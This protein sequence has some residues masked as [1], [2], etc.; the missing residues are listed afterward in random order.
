VSCVFE[1]LA[2]V[3]GGG[4]KSVLE[5]FYTYMRGGL[6]FFFCLKGEGKSQ[7]GGREGGRDGA[8]SR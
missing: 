8:S 3:L 2:S 4:G 5:T 1:L 6:A 7:E